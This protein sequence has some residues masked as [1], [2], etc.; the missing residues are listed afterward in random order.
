[1]NCGLLF[2]GHSSD[3]AKICRLQKNT[4]IMLG[5]ISRDSS[6]N[7]FKKLKILPLPSQYL[8]SLLF[9]VIKNRNQYTVNSEIH[10]INTRQHLNFH[11]PLPSLINANDATNLIGSYL[12]YCIITSGKSLSEGQVSQC[13]I[14]WDL[15]SRSGFASAYW[16]RNYIIWKDSSKMANLRLTMI[17]QYMEFLLMYLS[18]W[19]NAPYV[20]LYCFL[21]T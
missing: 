1:M 12:M 21:L 16:Q 5:W 4:R 10:H 15:I 19:H 14:L 3:S 11:Q 9:F 13:C 7:L 2:W 20:V 17:P 18:I 6:T 8:F